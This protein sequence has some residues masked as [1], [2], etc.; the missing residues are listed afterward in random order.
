MKRMNIFITRTAFTLSFF[1]FVLFLETI[2][3]NKQ[4]GTVKNFLLYLLSPHMHSLPQDQYSPPEQYICYSDQSTSTHH[5][6][7]KTVVCYRVHC[8]WRRFNGF[9]QM[10]DD[11]DLPLWYHTEQFLFC[12]V[13]LAAHCIMWEKYHYFQNNPFYI[14][15]L[16]STVRIY[17]WQYEFNAFSSFRVYA[18]PFPSVLDAFLPHSLPGYT[19]LI[20]QT[21]KKYIMSSLQTPLT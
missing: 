19:F 10:S 11:T 13:L 3:E 1:Y 12:F 15:R 21:L 5:Y 4:N 6:L 17:F 2:F 7:P 16:E 14:C 18:I 9:G 8:W 20:F